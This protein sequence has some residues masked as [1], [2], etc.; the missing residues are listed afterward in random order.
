[1]NALTLHK[2]V[3]IKLI[4]DHIFNKNYGREKMVSSLNYISQTQYMKEKCTNSPGMNE[5]QRKV[6]IRKVNKFICIHFKII[7][8]TSKIY[9]NH[10]IHSFQIVDLIGGDRK[11][12]LFLFPILLFD[13]NGTKDVNIGGSSSYQQHYIRLFE[14]YLLTNMKSNSKQFKFKFDSAIN[15]KHYLQIF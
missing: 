3:L 5:N 14:D 1:M 9:C 2:L 12:F 6:L 13:N 11:V 8:L 15:M 10:H 4:Y 7:L